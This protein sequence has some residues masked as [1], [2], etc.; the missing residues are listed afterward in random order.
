MGELFNDVLVAA[1][2]GNDRRNVLVTP[3]P[4]AIVVVPVVIIV[5][6]FV[7]DEVTPGVDVYI[8]LHKIIRTG[9]VLVIMLFVLVVPAID[10]DAVSYRAFGFYT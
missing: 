2:Y 10:D 7:I 1:H 5:P 4:V 8:N 6:A 3:T 9:H